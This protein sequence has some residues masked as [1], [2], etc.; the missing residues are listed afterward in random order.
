M[1]FSSIDFAQLAP[2]SAVDPLDYETIYA[3]RQDRFLEIWDDARAIDPTLPSFDAIGLESDPVAMLL[4]ESAYRELILRQLVND[5]TL[6]VLLPYAQGGGIDL[7]GANFG[8]ARAEAEDDTRFRR[9]VQLAPE[10]LASAGTEGG[11]IF[12]ALTAAPL[13]LDAKPESTRP[14]RVRV[15]IMGAGESRLPTEADTLAVRSRLAHPDVKPLTDMVSVAPPQIVP[16]VVS[17]TVMVP[18]GP[19]LAV[20]RARV[21]AALAEYLTSRN[22]LG[23]LIARSGIV[24]A[25]HQPGVVTVDLTSPAADLVLAAN[26]AWRLDGVNVTYGV[27]S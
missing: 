24:G 20:V 27:A 22:R 4:Q 16:L 18:A 5:R 21:D 23:A 2:P 1:R 14:G 3:E 19:D 9:R 12:H 7:L 15:T 6:S 26:E 25:L 17:A 10:A 8:V 11:Y 13:V